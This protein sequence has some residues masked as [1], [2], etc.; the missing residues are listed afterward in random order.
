MT[1]IWVLEILIIDGITFL[2]VIQTPQSIYR[3]K[4]HR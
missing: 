2:E 4:T 1:N 3:N